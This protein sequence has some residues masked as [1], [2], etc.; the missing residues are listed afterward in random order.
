MCS[1]IPFGTSQLLLGTEEGFPIGHTMSLSEYLASSILVPDDDPFRSYLLPDVRG[2]VDYCNYPHLTVTWSVP[3]WKTTLA[4]ATFTLLDRF[5]K[6]PSI[7]LPSMYDC[8][9]YVSLTGSQQQIVRET[10]WSQLTPLSAAYGRVWTMEGGQNIFVPSHQKTIHSLDDIIVRA[11][12]EIR[13][14]VVAMVPGS[15]SVLTALVAAHILPNG[16][17]RPSI[18]LVAPHRIPW[19]TSELKAD[20]HHVLIC[21]ELPSTVDIHCLI[22]EDAHLFRNQR[23][24]FHNPRHRFHYRHVICLVP[25]LNKQHVPFL[26]ETCGMNLLRTGIPEEDDGGIFQRCACVQGPLPP[27]GNVARVNEI[28]MIYHPLVHELH[29]MVLRV[30]EKSVLLS[31]DIMKNE[32]F[33]ILDMG[34]CVDVGRVKKLLLMFSTAIDTSDGIVLLVDENK[35]MSSEVCAICLETCLRPMALECK[36]EFCRN[37]LEALLEHGRVPIC[38]LCRAPLMSPPVSI[39]PT[40]E[41]VQVTHKRDSLEEYFVRTLS[42]SSLPNWTLGI[43]L[44]EK[45]NHLIPDIQELFRKKNVP[46]GH[47][48]ETPGPS[49]FWCQDIDCTPRLLSVCTHV[50]V[51]SFVEDTIDQILFS[52]T[53]CDIT[54]LV[55]PADSLTYTTWKRLRN[56]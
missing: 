28:R 35:S 44:T 42:L 20:F 8:P 1:T 27:K 15:G 18:L 14:S 13:G 55:S 2:R 26:A 51:M 11:F 36:H 4:S 48:H 6:T 17:R 5:L 22:I 7:P 19:W 40:N 16:D 53:K 31:R 43:V 52:G 21:S 47:S 54:I 29:H 41:I 37:C 30:H 45:E 24:L 50:L 49:V 38:P 39:P 10:V 3:V 34:G 23:P 12:H 32:I 46:V 25:W 33:S 9:T 56:K